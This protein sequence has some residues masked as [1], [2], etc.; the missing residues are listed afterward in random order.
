M[1]ISLEKDSEFGTEIS[2]N[3]TKD[4]QFLLSS[5]IPAIA[6]LYLVITLEA[7]TSLWAEC[8]SLIQ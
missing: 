6:T 5:D 1:I 2:F 8:I 4:L 3:S 7:I